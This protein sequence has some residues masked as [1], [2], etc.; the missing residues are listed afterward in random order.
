MR[1]R[2][3]AASVLA[4]AD[5]PFGSAAVMAQRFRHNIDIVGF[6]DFPRVPRFARAC[7]RCQKWY[8]PGLSRDQVKGNGKKL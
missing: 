1:V 6:L 4:M 8:I 3:L 7:G 5:F 2:G